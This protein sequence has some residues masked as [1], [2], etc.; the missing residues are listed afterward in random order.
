MKAI[1]CPHADMME[2]PLEA[3]LRNEQYIA[4]HK[5]K[6][7]QRRIAAPSGGRSNGLDRPEHSSTITIERRWQKP[8]KNVRKD[9]RC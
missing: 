2:L 9:V 1:L 8:G 6:Q 4:G 5:H 3:V 7:A